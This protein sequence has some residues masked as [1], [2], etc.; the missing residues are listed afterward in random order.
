M[1]YTEEQ[2]ET[3]RAAIA[4]G[5][6]EV[7]YKDRTVK[8]GTLAEMRATLAEMLTDTAARPRRVLGSFSR[9]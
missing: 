2:V 7:K 3:L 1:A 6:T 8:Y 9:D 5:V 4:R